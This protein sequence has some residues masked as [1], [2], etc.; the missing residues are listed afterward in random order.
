MN[1]E[2]QDPTA[3]DIRGW[4]LL[5]WGAFPQL[6]QM[7]SALDHRELRLLALF[8]TCVANRPATVRVQ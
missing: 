3:D 2:L 4:L 1:D 8:S 6:V 5:R 7:V